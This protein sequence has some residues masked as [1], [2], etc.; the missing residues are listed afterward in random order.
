MIVIPKSANNIL[1]ELRHSADGSLTIADLAAKTGIPYQEAQDACEYLVDVG[2]AR[3]GE[4]RPLS[5]DYVVI[6][7]KG[8]YRCFYNF[9]AGVNF[10]MNSIVIPII[11]S[12]VSAII[13]VLV[14]SA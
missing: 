7:A 4:P 10:F 13:V 12:V 3:R 14:Q 5:S 2:F 8:R 9:N 11:V 1:K 6:T